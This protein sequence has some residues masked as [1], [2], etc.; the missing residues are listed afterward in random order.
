MI[1][2]S[3]RSFDVPFQAQSQLNNLALKFLDSFFVDVFGAFPATCYHEARP[4]AHGKNPNQNYRTQ[5]SFRAV[6]APSRVFVAVRDRGHCGKSA[7]IGIPSYRLV[8]VHR[9]ERLVFVVE[10]P[11]G[12]LNLRIRKALIITS[13][14][15]NAI[16]I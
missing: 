7:K 12:A 9:A 15:H 11:S 10:K 13:T 2:R 6:V 14:T 5:T 3:P 1:L 16:I 4:H 8:E